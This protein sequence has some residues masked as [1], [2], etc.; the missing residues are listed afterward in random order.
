MSQPGSG[1]PFVDGS[2]AR[3]LAWWADW[4]LDGLAQP[5]Q[6]AL[7][8]WT[9]DW[10]ESRPPDV[11]DIVCT[12][13]HEKGREAAVRW[14][15][16]GARGQAAAWIAAGEPVVDLRDLLFGA[17][18]G[19]PSRP[20]GI[21]EAV[22]SRAWAA[23]LN[24]LR[25]CLALDPGADDAQP[26]PV[27]FRPWSGCVAVSVLLAGTLPQSLLLNAECVRSVLGERARHRGTRQTREQ[28]L[29]LMGLEKAL[30][31]RKLPILVEL[32][33]CELDLGSLKGLRVGDIVPLPHRLNMP[34][35]VST[36]NNARVCAGFL[37]RHSGLRAVELVPGSKPNEGV[38]QFD[39]HSTKE[40]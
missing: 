34:L 27:L 9:A 11:G 26:G 1:P 19:A 33:G 3:M 18:P 39:H 14:T 40:V 35:L 10:L 31:N 32:E 38:Y 5:L 25:A 15:P 13:A 29:A 8:A 28:R 12:L 30:A 24:G 23:L 16:L 20:P 21:A 6:A 37:G 4:Q 7:S 2:S 22:A 17:P 36:T